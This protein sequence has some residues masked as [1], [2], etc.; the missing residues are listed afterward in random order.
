V[1]QTFASPPR[2][3]PLFRDELRRLLLPL[4]TW[5]ATW[6]ATWAATWAGELYRL[7]DGRELL[8]VVPRVGS[9]LG[10]GLGPGVKVGGRGRGRVRGFRW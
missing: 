7:P 4:P 1:H 6:P 9:G 10:M 8:D 5:P 3:A 2:V